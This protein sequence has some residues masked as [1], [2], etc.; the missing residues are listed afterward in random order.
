MITDMY[1]KHRDALVFIGCTQLHAD[2]T[3]LYTRMVTRQ[4]FIG[5]TRLYGYSILWLS[6]YPISVMCFDFHDLS[7]E[8]V[9]QTVPNMLAKTGEI[10]PHE[11]LSL[12]HI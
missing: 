12:I 5:Y 10:E 3:R 8:F 4:V 1:I 7:F 6:D 9:G 11:I 2:Y